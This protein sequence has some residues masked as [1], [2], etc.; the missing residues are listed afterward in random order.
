MAFTIPCLAVRGSTGIGI[1][2]GPPTYDAVSS[3]RKDDSKN[4]KAM[5]F[6]HKGKY[7]AWIN[8]MVVKVVLCETWQVVATIDR[9]KVQALEFSPQDT[10]LMT[11]EPFVVSP[12]NQQSTPNLCF[13]D[14][15]SGNLVKSFVHKKQTDWEPEWSKDEKVCG[16]LIN[17]DVV[18]YEDSNFDKILHRINMA[19]IGRFSIAPSTAPYHV[20]CHMP[21]KSGQ[22][23]FGR[24]F[25]YP[26]FQASQPIAN[27]SFFQ[28]DRVDFYW[29]KHGTSVL[30][31]SSAEV[32]KTGSSYYGKQT[33]HY[34]DTK[35][36]TALVT[37]GKE[38]PIHAVQWSPK[39][40]EF[41]AIYGFMPSKATLF[42]MKC[43]PVFEFG[44][45]H[46]NT[47]CFNPFGNI[48][49]LTGFGNLRGGVELW[50]MEKRKLIATS[51][52]P[53]S[54]LLEWS[55]DGEHYM[56]ATTA[57]RLRMSNGF[58]IFHYTGTLLYERPWNK[59]EEL[60]QVS[61]QKF[62]EGTF[63]EKPISYKAV[64]GIAPSQPQA[65]KQVYRP[66]SARGQP[67]TFKLHDELDDPKPTESNLSKNALKI[68]K[69]REAKKAK[70][71]LE[72]AQSQ[73][74]SS[75]VAENGQTNN[76]TPKVSSVITNFELSEDPEIN[77]KMKK[78]KQK[79]EQISKLK[80]Q[81]AQGK[82]LEINQLD[83]IKKE[84]EL[85][86]ELEQLVL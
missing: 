72:A 35:G 45:K 18:L 74:L 6:S 68:K 61:W 75:S 54:T 77:K 52:A 57:P 8:G 17:N 81:Q 85:L 59:Q 66:P 46:R 30:L 19:K 26:K 27:K 4:C 39:Q 56:T 41:L 83:K 37:L 13:W 65:S 67:S 51:D 76:P 11:W 36:Q 44:T 16:M 2:Q 64:E 40:T 25:Q 60:W 22:P 43:E 29:N 15:K 48:M 58:K 10:Y 12:A 14:P 33:L 32:D 24:L 71:E 49:I 9:P 42:N 69:K 7:F 31:L 53:D 20:A 79:L 28:D 50:D 23:S 34:L 84:S 70:K 47:I 55:P 73:T 1:S 63:K 38:G 5:A 86:K 78:I 82:Q 21:G 62:P 80:E 3:F